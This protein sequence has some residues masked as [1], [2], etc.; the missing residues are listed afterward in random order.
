MYMPKHFAETD[1]ERMHQ[2][3]RTRGFGTLVTVENGLPQAN[4]VPFILDGS[5]RLQCHL[6]RGNPAWQQIVNAP[7]VLV[8]FQGPDAYIS[9]NWYATKKET[10]KAVPTWNYQVVHAHGRAK[11]IDDPVWLRQHLENL[12]DQNERH[13]SDAWAVSDAPADYIEKMIGAI[14]GLEITIDCLEGKLKASQN[15]P[16][17]NR[18]GVK[19]GLDAEGTDSARAIGRYVP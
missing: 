16:E 7:D 6:A 10:G 18:L 8:I 19:D 3:I 11:A 4:H 15:Q 1:T 5:G 17:A 12:T 14:V 9:P 13:R 2:L